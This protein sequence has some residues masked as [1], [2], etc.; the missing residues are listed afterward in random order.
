MAFSDDKTQLV[1]D[2]AGVLH[3]LQSQA[4]QAAVRVQQ[5]VVILDPGPDTSMVQYTWNPQVGKWDIA[6]LADDS[7][8]LRGLQTGDGASPP[9]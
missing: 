1:K 7:G 9:A 8:A 4:A 6:T 3:N 5:V 2:I